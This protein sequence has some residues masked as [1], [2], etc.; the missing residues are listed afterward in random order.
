MTIM[1]LQDT[2]SAQ[3]RLP[4]TVGRGPGSGP[5][6]FDTTSRNTTLVHGG[7]EATQVKANITE[8]GI[9]FPGASFKAYTLSS[10]KRGE[11]LA[12]SA[13]LLSGQWSPELHVPSA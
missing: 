13:G 10:G 1:N 7:S 6:S 11:E 12:S 5:A 2:K 4:S 8:R 3:Y 9:W